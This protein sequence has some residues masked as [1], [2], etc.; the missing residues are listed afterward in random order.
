MENK[1]MVLYNRTLNNCVF[2]EKENDTLHLVSEI[3][4]LRGIAYCLEEMGVY[5]LTLSGL[6]HFIEI[7]NDIMGA[8]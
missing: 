2:Y 5:P 8:K 7:N 3:G 6:T 1:M 4:C